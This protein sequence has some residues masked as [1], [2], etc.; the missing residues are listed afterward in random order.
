[1][2]LYKVTGASFSLNNNLERDIEKDILVEI[3]LNSLGLSV[4][5]SV[6]V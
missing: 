3:A 5:P 2:Y 1:M 4:H 6:C